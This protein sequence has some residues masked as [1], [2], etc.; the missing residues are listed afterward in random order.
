MQVRVDAAAGNAAARACT[1][2][3]PSRRRTAAA[4]RDAAAMLRRHGRG[5]VVAE[6]LADRAGLAV[7]TR[8]SGTKWIA[9]PYSW[10]I[11]SASSASSTPP[12]PKR[13]SSIGW[14]VAN[15]LSLPVLVDPHAAAAALF[16][17]AGSRAEAEA[18][19]V[20][21]RLGHPVVGHDLLEAV[22][23]WRCSVNVFVVEHAGLPV[24]LYDLGAVA[25][26]GAAAVEVRQRDVV[27]RRL[28]RGVVGVLLVGQ[29]LVLE[30]ATGLGKKT[31]PVPVEP[32][33]AHPSATPSARAAAISSK[34]SVLP[35]RAP[36]RLV[37]RARLS[38]IGSCPTGCTSPATTRRTR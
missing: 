12:L 10:R 38:R 3:S 27:V 37:N 9:W 17:G 35:S 29:R 2:S 8:S 5:P 23:W 30:R 22:V 26:Q 7:R 6:A 36:L 31:V 14:S 1:R 16:D 33:R 21:L 24:P 18:L 25:A 20:H 28:E 4:R 34:P 13:S 32:C 19:D 11:T 15:E